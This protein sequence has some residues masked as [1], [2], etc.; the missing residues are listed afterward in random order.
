MVRSQLT[1]FFP[2]QLASIQ[3]LLVSRRLTILHTGLQ[4]GYLQTD[5]LLGLVIESLYNLFVISTPSTF[6]GIDQFLSL[7]VV[8]SIVFVNTCVQATV[9]CR[10]DS[11]LGNLALKLI[12]SDFSLFY[13]L[14]HAL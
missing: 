3:K 11:V 2:G 4:Y 7:G 14:L 10:V 9:R 12:L 1:V 6:D 8:P 5:L 13:E